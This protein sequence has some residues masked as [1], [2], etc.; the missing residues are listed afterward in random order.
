MTA[1]KNRW[2]SGLS[3]KASTEELLAGSVEGNAVGRSGHVVKFNCAVVLVNEVG[4]VA[5]QATIEYLLHFLLAAVAH[6]V[7]H[8][9]WVYAQD[10]GA[11]L[12]KKYGIVRV[13]EL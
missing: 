2:P 3:K 12:G 4:L 11:V 5:L 1:K 8:P 6:L 9:L 10:L 7:D 13:L